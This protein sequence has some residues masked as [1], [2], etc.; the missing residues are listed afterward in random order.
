MCERD[1]VVSLPVGEL[2]DPLTVEK[3]LIPVRL[4]DVDHLRLAGRCRPRLARIEIA[5][6]SEV[7]EQLAGRIGFAR[8]AVIGEASSMRRREPPRL[9]LPEVGE[10]LAGA[11]EDL[12]VL[13]LQ[14]GDLI[15]SGQLTEPFALL[16]PG[17][18]L[19]DDGIDAELGQHLANR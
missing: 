18:H 3:Q 1:P 8:V 11:A 10:D 4:R 13:G 14:D 7:F 6:L 19:P 12:S 16:R 2:T 9:A 15:C 5:R 17:L